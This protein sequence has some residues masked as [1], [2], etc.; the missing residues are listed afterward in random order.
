[1]IEPSR[2]PDSVPTDET[3]DPA[4]TKRGRGWLARLTPRVGAA[5]VLSVLVHLGVAGLVALLMLLLAS[6]PPPTPGGQVSVRLI[7]PGEPASPAAPAGRV[8]GSGSPAP[9]LPPMPDGGE[10]VVAP[11]KLTEEQA[12]KISRTID[13]LGRVMTGAT[14]QAATADLQKA[15]RQLRRELGLALADILGGL[16]ARK[17][18]LARAQ[19]AADAA[20]A[21]IAQ[22]ANSAERQR[23]WG[24]WLLRYSSLRG[25][26]AA[27]GKLVVFDYPAPGQYTYVTRIGSGGPGLETGPPPAGFTFR[28]L[29]QA[30]LAVWV[31]LCRKAGLNRKPGTYVPCA[32][33]PRKIEDAL[34]R[35][36]RAEMARRDIT[37]PDQIAQTVFDL[38]DRGEVDLQSLTLKS[39]L[40]TPNP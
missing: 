20:D 26:E 28:P 9:A 18:E 29:D 21:A 25:I 12:R 4:E 24:R 3:P 36:E 14:A 11:D 27:G 32:V 22:L 16:A 31:L 19:G 15:R 38:N 8:P 6:P 35:L 39:N 34:T 30:T 23:K 5:M 7:D 1:M 17:A 37:D 40:K 2:Q 33:Y 13:D 10:T